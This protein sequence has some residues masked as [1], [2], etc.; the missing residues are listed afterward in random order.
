MSP[1]LA[2]LQLYKRLYALNRSFTLV[3]A[4][5]ER[6][7]RLGFFRGERLRACSVATQELQAQVNV[8]LVEALQ[9]WESE[10]AVRWEKMRREWEGRIRDPDDVF[11]EA[12]NRKREIREQIRELK[13]SQECQRAT[14]KRPR[15]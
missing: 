5:C 8:E 6:L 13:Q 15:R 2:K 11:I 14:R 10:E 3:I 1:L 12:A 4:N 9:D 7:E